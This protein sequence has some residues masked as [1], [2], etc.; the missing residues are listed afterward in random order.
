MLYNHHHYLFPKL[1]ITPMWEYLLPPLTYK[2]IIPSL[3]TRAEGPWRLSSI[4]SFIQIKKLILI[5]V[6]FKVTKLGDSRAG[7]QSRIL[8]SFFF[9]IYL[10][11]FIIIIIFWLCWVFA[12]VW[13]LS[14]VAASGGH[15][16][17][18]CAGLS[19]SRP[20]LLRSTGS[21]HTGSAVVAHG[22][23]CSAACGIFPDQGSNPCPLHWQADSQPLRHQ[24]ST[25][26]LI[27]N[28]EL[29]PRGVLS[30]IHSILLQLFL[31]I[32]IN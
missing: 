16:S 11:I 29:S 32:Q 1:F 15:S 5:K 25:E 10:F 9:L 13:G 23:S 21:R 14:L 24:G 28:Q 27:L 2:M 19:L 18:R 22:P 4:T 7:T 30:A 8:D 20:L 6:L 3:N 12:S 31:V 26:F 17:S